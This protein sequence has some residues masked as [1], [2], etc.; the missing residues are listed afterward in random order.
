MCK[1]TLPGVALVM[2]SLF[3]SVSISGQEPEN[4]QEPEADSSIH[5]VNGLRIFIDCARRR[6]SYIFWRPGNEQEVEETSIPMHLWAR[7][8]SKA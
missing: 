7:K 5:R 6:P 1:T 4:A 2:I 3:I 8:S